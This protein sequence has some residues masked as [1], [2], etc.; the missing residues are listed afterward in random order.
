MRSL[1]G[2]EVRSYMKIKIWNS[3]N[4]NNNEDKVN[5]FFDHQL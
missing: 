4:R 2:I 5:N 3:W 1:Q